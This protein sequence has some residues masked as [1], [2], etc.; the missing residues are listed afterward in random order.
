MATAFSSN[1]LT[2][3]TEYNDAGQPVVEAVR[4]E[5]VLRRIERAAHAW[6]APEHKAPF[7]YMSGVQL[8]PFDDAPEEKEAALGRAAQV[9]STAY[10]TIKKMR[11][12][13]Q[14]LIAS[15]PAGSK[16]A[17]AVAAAAYYV[18]SRS[19]RGGSSSGG[20]GDGGGVPAATN[21]DP[22]VLEQLASFASLRC[23]AA[24]AATASSLDDARRMRGQLIG[25]AKD[26]TEADAAWRAATEDDISGA[27]KAPPGRHA[28]DAS[29]SDARR[30]VVRRSGG[31][32]GGGGGVGAD[33]EPVPAAAATAPAATAAPAAASA[34][35]ARTL[36][37]ITVEA[38]AAPG[39]AVT[40]FNMGEVV[41]A[42]KV[43]AGLLR[44]VRARR[45]HTCSCLS[46]RRTVLKLTRVHCLRMCS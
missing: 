39:A 14:R 8:A 21:Q 33:V 46:A 6:P 23:R 13:Q 19:V 5:D 12:A 25:G 40:V 43:D 20:G 1:R 31:G 42:L 22:E 28:G 9:I 15:A 29:R 37:R 24:A 35:R 41:A 44:K 17:A 26:A 4:S 2:I 3:L 18:V 10:E 32:G 34:S 45:L 38:A 11:D 16:S 27:G 30:R 36:P 7:E